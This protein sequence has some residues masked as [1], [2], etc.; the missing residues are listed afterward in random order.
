MA[1]KLGFSLVAPDAANH[2][3]VTTVSEIWDNINNQWLSVTVAGGDGATYT[4]GDGINISSD[5]VI[6]VKAATSS[7]YGGVKLG[8]TSTETNRAVQ[9]DSNGKAYVALQ[10]ATNAAKGSVQLSDSTTI[11]TDL[12]N[13]N[14]TKAV[15]PKA[16]STALSTAATTAVNAKFWTGTQAQY[17]ALTNYDSNVFYMISEA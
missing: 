11:A 5:N 12:T 1:L 14:D 3:G 13:Q 15:T 7:A 8:A 6:S 16:I 17:D 10:A 4:A 2:V 9:L